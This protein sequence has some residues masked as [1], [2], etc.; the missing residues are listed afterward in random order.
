MASSINISPQVVHP[1]TASPNSP[2]SLDANSDEGALKRMTYGRSGGSAAESPN[3]KRPPKR[4]YQLSFCGPKM[5]HLKKRDGEALWRE[6]IQYDFLHAV[7]TDP[8]KAFTNPHDKTQK[9]TFA[10]IYL[11]AMARSTKC[12]K[13]LAEKLLGDRQAGIKI[14]MV[15]L[16]VNSGRMNTT[17]NFFPE[18]KTQ[19]RTYHPIPSLQTDDTQDYKQLQ[20]AP[21]LKSI[22]KG[23][24]EGIDEAATMDALHNT[25]HIPRANPISLVFLMS[26]WAYEVKREMFPDLRDVTF[27]DLIVDTTKTSHSRARAFLWLVWTYMESP[28][29]KPTPLNPFGA[30]FPAPEPIDPH[31]FR[32]ENVDPPAELVFGNQMSLMRLA[33]LNN[34]NESNSEGSANGH[35]NVVTGNGVDPT[36]NSNVSASASD[37]TN[38][39]ANP[40]G[41]SN[42]STDG[43]SSTDANVNVKLS[44]SANGSL[45]V[46]EEGTN[47]DSKETQVTAVP[48][49]VPKTR[50]RSAK[51]RRINDELNA[52]VREKRE[53]R[54]ERRVKRANPMKDLWRYIEDTD[55]LYDSDDDIAQAKIDGKSHG[56][57][58]GVL[59]SGLKS[60]YADYG[61]LC[62][63]KALSLKRAA[64]RL[65]PDD[66]MKTNSNGAN[67]QDPVPK[68]A[69]VKENNDKDGAP[70]EQSHVKDE[71][72]T[73]N[74]ANTQNGVTLPESPHI[75]SQKPETVGVKSE[76]T[77]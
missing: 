63:S 29:I 69:K 71:P 4:Q 30:T 64:K 55:P 59:A 26:T 73:S 2:N 11:D 13:I 47:G 44:D 42:A 24:C 52:L 77:N 36:S 54:K 35:T 58:P 3:S 28:E 66:S 39:T 43:N 60:A 65:R 33:I 31:S 18:M 25:S 19:L 21:R 34:Y 22:L 49:I 27:F 20:D 38:A 16:L 15:C 5:H 68:E 57:K 74:T 67:S 70:V 9:C 48:L 53:Y 61:E 6:D 41:S 10:D 40:N 37:G 12:S 75:P 72:E 1:E 23:A 76:T 17:L 51:D 45:N 62:M 7:F 46:S 56:V 32:T 14:A 50:M 8:T